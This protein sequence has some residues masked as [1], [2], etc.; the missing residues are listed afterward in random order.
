[1][2]IIELDEEMKAPA[3]IKVIG[4]GGGGGNALNCMVRSGLTGVEYIAVNTDAQS[5]EDSMADHKFAIG[6]LGAGGQPD[7]GRRSMEERREEF[8]DLLQGADM[9]FIAAGMGGGT[10]TGAAPVIAEMS[11]ELGIL[12]VGVV[13]KPFQ[14]ENSVRKRHAA[15]GIGN[16]NQHV[17]TMLIIN[18]Q[19]IMSLS[20]EATTFYSGMKMADEVLTNAVRGVTDIVFKKGYVNVDFADIRSVLSHGGD[21]IMGLGGAE[22]ENRAILAAQRALESTLLDNI[23]IKGATGVLINICASDSLTMAEVNEAMNFINEQIGEGVETSSTF[24]AVIDP[25]MGNKFAVTIIAT[26]FNAVANEGGKKVDPF[27]EEKEEDLVAVTQSSPIQEVV[28]ESRA[29]ASVQEEPSLFAEQVTSELNTI[30]RKMPHTWELPQTRPSGAF[31]QVES[32]SGASTG[33]FERG[34]FSGF[35]PPPADDSKDYPA[36]LR[37]QAMK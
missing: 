9:V 25:E 32:K 5:L 24:G 35:H 3:R 1:M 33:A 6:S 16:L 14:W 11:R 20:G 28:E 19:Q 10:G 12:T 23:S 26:G 37:R 22:G 30:E 8:K 34:G 27:V 15:E 31:P 2:G 7:I 4:V 36:F 13:T 18:N 17:D 21:S 29:E